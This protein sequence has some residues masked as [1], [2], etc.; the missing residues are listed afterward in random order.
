MKPKN[1]SF[2]YNP[3]KKCR[4]NH[5]PQLTAKKCI[6]CGFDFDNFK[7]TSKITIAITIIFYIVLFISTGIFAFFI[8]GV[9]K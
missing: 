9:I 8:T 4:F 7:P 5:L 6:E 1:Q 3:C 2:K